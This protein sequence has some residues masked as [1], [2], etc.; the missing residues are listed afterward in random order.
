MAW[1]PPWVVDE[2]SA[3]AI[4]PPPPAAASPGPSARAGAIL[5]AGPL[6]HP[7]LEHLQDGRVERR[8]LARRRRPDGVAGRARPV[9]AVVALGDDPE[10]APALVPRLDQRRD[11]LVV[12][13][14]R[15]EVGLAPEGQGVGLGLRPGAGDV[16]VLELRE[17]GVMAAEHL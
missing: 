10:P 12:V 9:E 2:D 3:T 8:G 5:L 1:A 17:E 7:R 4:V 14:A 6:D 11:R 15:D 16:R 13:A